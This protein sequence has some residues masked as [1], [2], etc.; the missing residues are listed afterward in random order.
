HLEGTK[1]ICHT[2][3]AD[4]LL[5]INLRHSFSHTRRH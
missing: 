4:H 5:T 1:T 2:H 3:A